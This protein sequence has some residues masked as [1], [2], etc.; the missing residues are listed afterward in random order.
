MQRTDDAIAFQGEARRRHAPDGRSAA[1][2]PRAGACGSR[3]GGELLRERPPVGDRGRTDRL[4]GHPERGSGRAEHPKER[5]TSPRDDGGP[6]DRDT[7]AGDGRAADGVR[8]NRG[9]GRE[10]D[11]PLLLPLRWPAGGS[12]ALG[13]PRTV[14]PGA[15]G[16]D[17]GRLSRDFLA[18][19]R[20]CGDR[21]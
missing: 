19:R 18:A 14:G 10:P 20:G 8:R 2:S 13:G 11:D 4:P 12:D 7:A 9:A 6:G 17:A 21:G 5:H 15:A 16:R 1:R 3:G